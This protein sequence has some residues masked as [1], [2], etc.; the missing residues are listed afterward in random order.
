M[1][2]RRNRSNKLEAPPEVAVLGAAAVDWIAHV[3]EL[4]PR[5]GI[6]FADHYRPFPG[7][8]GGN[9]A[10]AVAR[11]GHSV[12]FLGVL[13]D[14]EG[15]RLLLQAFIEA[16]VDTRCMRTEK[17]QKSAAC[18]IAIDGQ[19][20]RMIFCLGGVAI[21]EKAEEIAP[22][23]L[24]GVRVLFIADAHPE[25][26]EA[27]IVSL[28]KNARVVFAPGG[29]MAEAGKEFLKPIL[30]RTDVL[31]LSQLEASKLTGESDAARACLVL[32]KL[33]PKV[34]MITLGEKGVLVCDNGRST[35]VPG[36]AVSP[37]VDTTGA[38]DAFSAGVIAGIL[39]G[40]NSE[41][42]ARL[43]CAIAAI[44]I[45][46]LGA[47]TGLP[48][49]KQVRALLEGSPIDKNVEVTS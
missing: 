25:V 35:Q 3:K 26:A 8:S 20:E 48:N 39:E 41:E 22:S 17:G 44:K 27:A 15:G 49:Q 29:L 34:S 42:A 37:V 38:G 23:W 45:Q 1:R 33:G 43:G 12:R 40:S 21:Y 14:D 36:I 46:H 24:K 7:G 2:K 18:F 31:I 28:D 47:R 4:P 19:G 6:V 5:D 16:G 10:E 30:N 9:T 13:G 11:L 32:T